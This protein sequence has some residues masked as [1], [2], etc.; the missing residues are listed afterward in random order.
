MWE[1]IKT[2]NLRG[3]RVKEARLQTL[4]TEFENM[5]M[6]DN[7]LEQVLDLKMTGFE[8]VVGRLK[9]YEDR[10]K[11]EDKASDP[12]ENLFYAR[13]E[14]SNGNNDSSGGCG[15][16]S[17]G[18]G[19]GRGQGRDRGNSQN[20]GQRDSSKNYKD[21]EQKGKQHKKCDL[22]HIQCYRCDQLDTLF[23]NALNETETMRLTLMRHKK[24][25][26]ILRKENGTNQVLNEE[27]NPHSNSVIVHKTS[28]ESE[29]DN[30]GSDDT[31]N[32]LVRIETIRLLIALAAEKGWKIHHL[33]VKKAFLNGDRKKLDGTLK[34][35]G[36]LQCVH[37]KAVYRKV[38]NGEFIIVVVYGDD[39]FMT[40]TSL[41]LIN[42]FKKRM[43]S[44]FEMS[45][46]GELSYYLGIEVSQ[47]KDCVEIKQERYAMKILKEAGMEDCITT[48][49]PM[50]PGLKLSKA[51]DEPEVE[52]T[53]YLKMVSCSRYL[54]HTRPDLTYSVGVVSRYMQSPRTSHAHA[55]KQI[56]RYPKGTTS[57]GIKY[58]RGNDMRLVGYNSH[59]VDIDDGRSTTGHVFYLGTSPITWCSQKQTTI[60]LSSC[61]A[62][63]MAATAATSDLGGY[64]EP[65]PLNHPVKP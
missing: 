30:S 33:D 53:Q 18:H 17:R 35:I 1:A 15:S 25:M 63:F 8:D 24:K 2:C 60:A 20:Q 65:P 6:L 29:E 56:L 40:G 51:E 39:L 44:Q 10:V 9:A 37:E 26:C 42:E 46:L 31:L 5:K 41:D 36:F 21:N 16:D 64:V 28:P 12:Q 58:K 34:E 11:K 55:I 54:L 27:A 48:L 7:A 43:A 23:Q 4:I 57:F 13:T 19:R 32:P 52:A 3:D 38:P 50:E 49:R 62:K 45:D 61:E 47:G 22:S 59:N 14:Y